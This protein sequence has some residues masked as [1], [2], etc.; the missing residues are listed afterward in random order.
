M[1]VFTSSSRIDLRLSANSREIPHAQVLLYIVEGQRN[2]L[3]LDS[4]LGGDPLCVHRHWRV[5]LYG[6][7]CGRT[8]SLGQHPFAS[9]GAKIPELHHWYDCHNLDFLVII[10]S[11]LGWLTVAGW[12]AAFAA[13]SFVVSSLIQNLAAEAQENYSPER[14]QGTLIY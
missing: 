9:S 3:Q 2:G 4:L 1:R 6:T 7:D 8:I 5:I 14:W 12:I 11:V 13:T 10:S